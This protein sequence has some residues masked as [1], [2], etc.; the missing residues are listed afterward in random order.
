MCFCNPVGSV[1][2]YIKP[3]EVCV[4]SEVMQ[5]NDI[6]HRKKFFCITNN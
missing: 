2:G 1:L 6:K 4:K 3:V 5:Y